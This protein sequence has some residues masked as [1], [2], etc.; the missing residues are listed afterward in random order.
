LRAAA[1]P[2]RRAGGFKKRPPQTGHFVSGAILEG[3]TRNLRP[4]EAQ[5]T[6]GRSGER[7]GPAAPPR[8]GSPSLMPSLRGLL[9]ATL[10]RGSR[11]FQARA[12]RFEVLTE[13]RRFLEVAGELEEARDLLEEFEARCAEKYP[14][15]T[16]LFHERFDAK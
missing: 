3:S 5:A 4:Q 15:H 14:E 6:A 16:R 10:P 11:A 13:L 2:G 9:S 8:V 1:A 7:S 12:V